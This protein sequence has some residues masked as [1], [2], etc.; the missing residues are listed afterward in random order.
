MQ[1]PTL[2][3][4]VQHSRTYGVGY[5]NEAQLRPWFRKSL[6]LQTSSLVGSFRKTMLF[7]STLYALM[8][9]FTLK[10]V[11]IKAFGRLKMA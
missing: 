10:G 4:L 2:E 7:L 9:L 8:K 11:Y 3:D 6:D 1:P 5:L